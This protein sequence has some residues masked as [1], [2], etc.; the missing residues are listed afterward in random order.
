MPRV[1]GVFLKEKSQ[2]LV[3]KGS[4]AKVPFVN[5]VSSRNLACEVIAQS[6]VQDCDDEGTLFS[7]PSLNIT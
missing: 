4:V 1:D 6:A 5:G 2:D 3:L 7:L